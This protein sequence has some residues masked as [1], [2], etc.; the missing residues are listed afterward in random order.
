MK[1]PPK[2]AGKWKASVKLKDVAATLVVTSNPLPVRSAVSA[3]CAYSTEVAAK[4]EPKVY[5]GD[6]MLGIG[7]VHKSG[8]Q[9]VFSQ[10]QAEDL[11]KMRR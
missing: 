4:V 2:F 1:S 6:K 9:P 8:L 5:T 7:V 11:A 3:S 10:E